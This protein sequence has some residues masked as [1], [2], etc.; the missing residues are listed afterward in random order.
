MSQMNIIVNGLHVTGRDEGAGGTILLL[1]GWGN[2]H[3]VF[4]ALSKEL[5][6]FRIIAPDL[7]GFG[8]SQPPQEPWDV[9]RYAEFVK[10]MLAKLDISKVDALIG[11]SFGGRIGLVLA[12]KHLLDI[13]KLVLLASH[14]LPE[15]ATL[16][17]S[18]ISTAAKI[19][20]IMPSGIR[21]KVG[22]RW[23]S[24]DYSAAEGVMKDTFKL[25]INQDA[26]DEA[27]AISSETLL[28][29]GSDDSTTPL[30]MGQQLHSLINGSRMEIIEGGG[31]HLLSDSPAQAARIIKEFLR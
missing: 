24:A 13:D 26:T 5:T 11:H 7:P 21:N 3:T 6:G 27:K 23:R 4:D 17:G 14:G 15:T 22:K 31:H 29:Y 18:A 8:G 30:E 28:I 25:V 20:K 1:H 19:G 16:K 2:D 10:G 9:D 12:G